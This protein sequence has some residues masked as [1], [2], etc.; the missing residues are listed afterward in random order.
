MN[1]KKEYYERIYAEKARKDE[2]ALKD[3]SFQPNL[4]PSASNPMIAINPT[5]LAPNYL[6]NV[7]V[8]NM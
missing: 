2:E 6:Q 3:C 1:E 5:N 7:L 8:K 4:Y